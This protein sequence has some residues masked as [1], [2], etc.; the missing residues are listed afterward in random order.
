[1][2]TAGTLGILKILDI[3][4]TF[5]IWKILGTSGNLG[6]FRILIIAGIFRILRFFT[7]GKQRVT[8]LAQYKK[9]VRLEQGSHF[10][11]GCGEGEKSTLRLRLVF[12]IINY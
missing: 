4:G 10:I 5:V 12:L 7:A 6:I 8:A 3:A 9:A 1:M 2:D 11:A